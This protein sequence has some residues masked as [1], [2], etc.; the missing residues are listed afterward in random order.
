MGGNDLAD[1]EGSEAAVVEFLGGAEGADIVSRQPNSVAR[2]ELRR[3]KAVF[4]E[5]F[6]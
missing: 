6:S 4:I 5:L 3:G 2:L 1:R